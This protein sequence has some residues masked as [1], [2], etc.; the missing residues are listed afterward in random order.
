MMTTM[1]ILGCLF[2]AGIILMFQ[3]SKQK[4]AN[5]Q[6]KYELIVTLRHLII[7]CRKHRSAT[8]SG[9]ISSNNPKSALEKINSLLLEQSNHLI[10]IAHFN[11]K[12]TYRILQMRLSKLSQDWSE[13][14]IARN[15]ITHGAAIRH[16][17]YSIDEIVMAWL[18]ETDQSELCYQYHTNWQQIIDSMEA[19]TQLRISI[20]D[21]DTKNG[22]LRT[23]YRCT[24]MRR[25][26]N[27]LALISPLSIASPACSRAMHIMEEMADNTD[28]ALSSNELYDLTSD[29][30]ISITA[31]YDQMLSKLTT[32]LYVPLPKMTTPIELQ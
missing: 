28:Y 21:I 19:L 10:S 31:V 2:L 16:C 14:T 24:A 32:E 22:L 8:H 9:L 3:A 29:I 26:L 11:N 23:Q 6:R 15:Q 20:Q 12:P 30:S 17:M 25:K 27:Q 5:F 13:R 18:A 7:L 4:Q 1:A